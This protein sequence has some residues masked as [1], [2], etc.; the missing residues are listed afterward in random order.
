MKNLKITIVLVFLSML[1]SHGVTAQS[2]SNQFDDKKFEKNEELVSDIKKISLS[3][4]QVGGFNDISKKYEIQREN[5]LESNAKGDEL[6]SKLKDIQF[7][8][9]KEMK[10]FLSEE[11]YNVYIKIQEERELKKKNKG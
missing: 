9:N 1:A 4:S 5:L 3:S 11:Q 7:Q 2:N 10:S 8:K 6:V